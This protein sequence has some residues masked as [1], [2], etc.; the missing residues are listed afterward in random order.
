MPP[1]QKTF[2]KYKKNNTIKHEFNKSYSD[3]IALNRIFSPCWICTTTINKGMYLIFTDLEKMAKQCTKRLYPDTTAFSIAMRQWK[4]KYSD[5]LHS[6]E[7][8]I[9][10]VKSIHAHF[11][12]YGNI[13][14]QINHRRFNAD[15]L[16]RTKEKQNTRIYKNKK[17]WDVIILYLCKRIIGEYNLGKIKTVRKLNSDLYNILV[18]HSEFFTQSLQG[19]FDSRDS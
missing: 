2:E 12:P 17:C 15:I 5:I 3:L 7:L 6:T 1:I 9:D 19:L 10:D 18:N 4:E 11:S 14:C 13:T 8:P 16:F